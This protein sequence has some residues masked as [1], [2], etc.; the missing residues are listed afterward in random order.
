MAKLW[1]SPSST[2]VDA[3]RVVIAIVG[4]L[5]E[6]TAWKDG[7]TVV[8]HAQK[9]S[10]EPGPFHHVEL[11]AGAAQGLHW[12]HPGALDGHDFGG[13]WPRKSGMKT[14]IDGFRPS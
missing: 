3:R 1:P 6:N 2:V 10:V 13:G 5:G 11:D 4:V 12:P 8:E 14:R 9:N 7:L